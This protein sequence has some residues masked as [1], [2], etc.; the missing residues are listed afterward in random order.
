MSEEEWVRCTNAMP[1]L[2]FLRDEG[3]TSERK[4]RLFA[5]TCCRRACHLLDVDGVATVETSERFADGAASEAELK[6][7]IE[8]NRGCQN[9]PIRTAVDNAAVGAWRPTVAILADVLLDDASG[10]LPD[11]GPQTVNRGAE[12]RAQANL[13]RD[14]L[15]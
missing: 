14:V 15:G 9:I 1:M 3:T 11:S 7:A 8:A 10:L 2:E 4:L 5:A 12:G 6:S 13:L